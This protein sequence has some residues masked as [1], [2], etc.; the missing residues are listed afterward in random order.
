MFVPETARGQ[1]MRKY[2]NKDW[3]FTGHFEERLL[4]ISREEAQRELTPVY[5]PH[6]VKELP[7]NCFDEREYQMVSG[8]VRFL[9]VP[10]SW[11][12]K[13][14]SLLFMA[15]GHQAEVYCNGAL[16]T[17]HENGYTAFEAELDGFLR[18]GEENLITVRLDSRENLN[19]PPFGKVIDYMTFGGLYR[20]VY[21][22]VRE[23]ACI[24]DLFVHG[25]LDGV[26][27]VSMEGDYTENTSVIAR[28]C[29]LDSEGNAEGPGV[30][31]SSPFWVDKFDLPVPDVKLWDIGNPNMYRLTV[32]MMGDGGSDTRSA[33]FGFRTVRM[34]AEGFWLNERRL[35][36]RGLNRHQSWPYM[37]YAVPDRAQALDADILKY[38][39][40]C[41]AVRTSHYSQSQ[42]F[43][44]RCDRI[45]L[46]V[47]TEIPGWQFVGDVKWQEQALENTREMVRQYRNHPSIFLWGVRINESADHDD[48]YRKTNAV[49]RQMDPTRPTGGVRCIKNSH[50]FEDVYTYNDFSHYGPNEGCEPR[51]NITPEKKCGYLITEYNGHMYPTKAWDFEGRRV[52]HALRHAR[53]LNAVR[54]TKGIAGSFGWCMFDYNTHKDFGSG[55]RICYHGVLDMFRNPKLAAAVYTAEG[56]RLALKVGTT[57]DIGEYPAARLGQIWAFTS[58]S[59]VELYKNGQFVNRF[60]PG[61]QFPNMKHPPILIDDVIGNLLVE[62]EGF[63]E[64]TAAKVKEILLAEGVYGEDGLPSALARRKALLIARRKV[65]ADQL[66]DLYG[67]YLANWGGERVTWRF[68]AKNEQGKVIGE[69]IRNSSAVSRLEV[70]CD[71]EELTENGTWDIATVRIRAV[72]QNG[73]QLPYVQRSVRLILEGDAR[74]AGPDAVP[75][76]GGM[77]GTYVCSEGRSGSAKLTIRMEGC[78]DVVL[79][80]TIRAGE[81]AK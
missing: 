33:D 34:D 38:E 79:H 81:E 30:M 22:E 73:E 40:G 27:H 44:D 60:T 46:L 9:N 39:L 67:R 62:N 24:R 19:Q 66:H 21:L 65:T 43:V 25:G 49:A 74:L 17:H 31:F 58:G 10:E 4:H 8:Y 20:G 18:Y 53:V 14:V 35:R 47:F 12:G 69:C 54:G 15:A 68:A 76:Q 57:M 71:T 37:G 7:F 26:A 36:I 28:I 41:N 3:F 55:D 13:R 56:G 2:F 72:D 50:L 6:T 23:K 80:F 16:V 45:G 64:K 11:R 75:L 1:T 42:A 61:G 32:T 51:E 77:T 70:D 52:E 63:D 5:L 48:L 78:E 29:P 59:E